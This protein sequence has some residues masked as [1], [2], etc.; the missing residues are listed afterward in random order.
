[1]VNVE[2]VGVA[3]V[4]EVKGHPEHQE[5]PGFEVIEQGHEQLQD[6]FGR[7]VVPALEVEQH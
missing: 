1:L 2:F 7:L 5:S 6:L 4:G 3:R